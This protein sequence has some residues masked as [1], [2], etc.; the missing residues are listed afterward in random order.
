MKYSELLELIEKKTG[1]RPSHTIISEILGGKPN[2]NALNSRLYNNGNVKAS[3]LIILQKYF[4]LSEENITNSEEVIEIENI[5]GDNLAGK[6]IKIPYWDGCP[7]CSEK[8]RNPFITECIEDLQVII[9]Q[10][11]RNPEDLKVIAMPG[12]EMDGG[13]YPLRNQD[14]L[15]IDTSQTDISNSGVYFITTQNCTIVSVRRLLER[16]DGDILSTVDNPLYAE[17][18][19][20]IWTKKELEEM[21]FKVIGRIIKNKSIII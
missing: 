3:E 18:L 11:K 12:D 14:I 10:W 1:I 20:N 5:N 6:Y 13:A 16:M 17:K 9:H 21:D 7:E 4:D 8:I 15:I 2:A 19:E